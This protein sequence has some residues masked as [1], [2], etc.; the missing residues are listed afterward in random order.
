MIP[1]PRLRERAR[2]RGRAICTKQ[3]NPLAPNPNPLPIRFTHGERE[4]NNSVT[5][6]N[7]GSKIAPDQAI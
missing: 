7:T 6:T 5:R 3:A 4:K 2:E 1:S